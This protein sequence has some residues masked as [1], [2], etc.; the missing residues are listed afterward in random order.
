M[1]S[2]PLPQIVLYSPKDWSVI[3][4]DT[5]VACIPD[6]YR[7]MRHCHLPYQT[8]GFPSIHLRYAA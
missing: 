5:R 3:V 2:E 8:G 1:V 7:M 6:D 4:W